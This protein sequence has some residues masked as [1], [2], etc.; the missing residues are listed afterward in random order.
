M[1]KYDRAYLREIERRYRERVRNAVCALL[2]GVCIKCGFSD[3]R[4]LQVDHI[5]GNGHKERLKLKTSSSLY[6]KILKML[7]PE[8]E[9]Q[10]L[11]ANCNWIKRVERGEIPG[12]QAF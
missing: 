5:A 10:L 11:C 7:H 4:A 6:R 12:V 3:R 1:R 9:Y 8:K 2:G